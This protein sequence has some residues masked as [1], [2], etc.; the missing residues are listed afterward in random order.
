MPL[1]ERELTWDELAYY[2]DKYHKGGRPARTL[3]MEDVWDWAASR[4]DLFYVNKDKCICLKE[5]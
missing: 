1:K 3:P 2:Y 4:K 5:V